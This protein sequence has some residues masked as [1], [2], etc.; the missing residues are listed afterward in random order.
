VTKREEYNKGPLIHQQFLLVQFLC[1]KMFESPSRSS[2]DPAHHGSLHINV[3][4]GESYSTGLV[5]CMIGLM[6]LKYLM[7]GMWLN[8]THH[9]KFLTL[10][11]QGDTKTKL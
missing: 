2:V 1:Q 10:S 4:R 7:P 5:Y 8:Q 6:L 9:S 11:H 3:K